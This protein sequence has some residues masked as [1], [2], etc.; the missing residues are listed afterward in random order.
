MATKHIH[1]QHNTCRLHVTDT[2]HDIDEF[3]CILKKSSLNKM[4]GT[5]KGVQ[6]TEYS[7]MGHL[8]TIVTTIN[9]TV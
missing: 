7:Q 6:T 5:D 8:L 2:N 9:D 1:V 4:H 3:C